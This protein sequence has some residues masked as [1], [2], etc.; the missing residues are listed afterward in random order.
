VD[1]LAE[2]LRAGGGEKLV[3]ERVTALSES[4]R[5]SLREA[6]AEPEFVCHQTPE[7]RRFVRSFLSVVLI[8]LSRSC[9]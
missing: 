9:P 6:L 2:L 7:R 3:R 4:E 5:L 1:E 8:V